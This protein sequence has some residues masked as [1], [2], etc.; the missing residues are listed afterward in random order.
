MKTIG[1][2]LKHSEFLVVRIGTLKHPA[3]LRR[4]SESTRRTLVGIKPT[5][6]ETSVWLSRRGLL[7][8]YRLEEIVAHEFCCGVVHKGARS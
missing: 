4:N 8:P 6:D 2:K 1:K 5:R 3:I 7:A